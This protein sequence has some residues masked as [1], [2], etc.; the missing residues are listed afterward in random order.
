MV[1]QIS[2][3]QYFEYILKTQI[4]FFLH[5]IPISE[6]HILHCI[7]SN[8]SKNQH[9]GTLARAKLGPSSLT[10]SFNTKSSNPHQTK[11]FKN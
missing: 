10:S 2:I 11:N 3:D 8:I 7:G 1:R 9:L 6:S 4:V 5:E